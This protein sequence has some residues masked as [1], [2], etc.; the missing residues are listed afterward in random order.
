M[1]WVRDAIIN[2]ETPSWINSVP[3]NFGEASHGVLKAD[4]W[5]TLSTI[6][7]PLALVT[8]WGEGTEHKSSADAS[9]FR[10]I[11]D[12]T[13]ALVSAIRLACLRIMTRARAESYRQLMAMY[14]RELVDIYPH[15]THR[16]NHHVSFHIYDFLLLFG[17]V[18][19]WWCFPFERLIG[20]L[21]RTPN[22]HQFGMSF[23][24]SLG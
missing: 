1:A 23:F 20:I 3:K 18:H 24:C 10:R 16:P 4:E 15:A 6:Y 9:N 17:P 8:L 2:T 11:L 19:S 14:V 13:M 21:Q 7:L 5:R 22:N 12:H